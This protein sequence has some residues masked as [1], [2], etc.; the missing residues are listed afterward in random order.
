MRADIAQVTVEQRTL[1]AAPV[2]SDEAERRLDDYLSGL[3]AQWT[4]PVAIDFTMGTDY[5][6]PSPDDY[7]PHKVAVLLANL[8]PLRDVLRARLRSAYERLPASVPSAE[9]PAH[10]ADLVNR[11]RQLELQEEQLILEAAESGMA[12]A[13]RPDADPVVVLTTVLRAD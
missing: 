9:R 3:A 4:P 11:R 5:R 10:A 7:A 6:P 12:I 2:P 8:P 1:D 13:R